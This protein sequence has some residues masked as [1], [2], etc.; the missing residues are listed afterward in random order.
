[1]RAPITAP[2]TPLDLP[3]L[4]A[5][6]RARSA[7]AQERA[8]AAAVAAAAVGPTMSVVRRLSMAVR[9]SPSVPARPD[10]FP[11]FPSSP[12]GVPI[13]SAEGLDGTVH[14]AL[15]E[16]PA[17]AAPIIGTAAAAGDVAGME[18]SAEGTE[19][20]PA[21]A[22]KENSDPAGTIAVS[23]FGKEAAS[24]KLPLGEQQRTDNNISGDVVGSDAV[25]GRGSSSSGTMS[26]GSKSHKRE[27]LSAMRV[28]NNPLYSTAV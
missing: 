17:M 1:M 11:A 2:V 27:S 25:T 22:D 24:A 8:L 16:L 21:E 5:A 6:A 10:R 18:D 20:S 13:G 26:K 3:G 28:F 19:E 12:Q 23:R 7:A 14:N 4:L 15:L 9:E